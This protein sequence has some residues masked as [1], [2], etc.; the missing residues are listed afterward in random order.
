[1]HKSIYFGNILEADMR[2]GWLVY[3]GQ[4]MNLFSGLAQKDN[5]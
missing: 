5:F 3:K 2:F 4:K 1:L